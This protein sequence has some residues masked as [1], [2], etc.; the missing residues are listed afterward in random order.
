MD[1]ATSAVMVLL[2][3]SPDMLF[4]RRPPAEAPEIVFSTTSHCKDALKH[5]LATAR[6]AGRVTVGRCRPIGSAAAAVRW[7]LSPSRELLTSLEPEGPPA[8]TTPLDAGTTGSTVQRAD[9]KYT[10][11]RVTYGSGADAVTTAY[12]VKRSN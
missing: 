4:C 8:A 11:V 5:R 9:L 6:A 7:G 3:C 10:T 2:W 12:V 1:P